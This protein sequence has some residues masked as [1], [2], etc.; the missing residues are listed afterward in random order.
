M[1]GT[2][3]ANF[4]LSG[5]EDHLAA[6]LSGGSS[7]VPV[8]TVNI[9]RE[10]HPEDLAEYVEL[11]G[12]LETTQKSDEK[13]VNS[14]RAKHHSVARLLAMGLPE[15]VVASMTN[16]TPAYISTLK[17]TP[18]ML[19]LIAH[20]R[21]PGNHAVSE[22]VEKLRLLGNMSL[23]QL[24]ARAESGELNSQE[25]LQAAKLGND[26][27]GAGPMQKIEHNHEHSLNEEQVA[28]LARSAREANKGRVI[29]I[30]AVRK[31][32]PAPKDDDNADD[33]A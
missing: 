21:A 7:K 3:A 22:Q 29:D 26:R 4:D 2:A 19:E 28:R 12:N 23:D 32:L 1:E 6:E 16:Y 14:I 27:S 24:I 31:Q 13:D 17:N 25:L 30:S 33:A 18:A 9:E 11:N 5:I 20:Y 8:V 15:G 10:L